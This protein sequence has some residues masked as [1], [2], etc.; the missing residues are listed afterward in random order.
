MLDQ[1]REDGFVTVESALDVG[2]CEE[3]VGDAFDRM[4]MREQDPDSWPSG[5]TNLPVVRNWPL[6]EVAPAAAAVVHDLLA[7]AAVRFAGV[8]DNLIVNLPEPGAR[9]WPPSAAPS[10]LGG[11]HKDGDW[12]RHFLDSPE[13]A[14]LVIV[15][16]RD[17]AEDQG[18]TYAAC[19]SVRPVAELLA[20]HPGGLDP[21]ELGEATTGI[22]SQCTDFRALT[23]R[24]GT[25]VFAHPFL[26]HTASVNGTNRPRV[27]SNSSVML[28][29]PM[30]FDRPARDHSVLE[31]SILDALG[32]DRLD[33]RPTGDRRRVT[34]ERARRW[35]EAQT[36]THQDDESA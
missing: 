29:E 36:Q 7:P 12:F 6:E 25:I 4:G 22:V 3:V 35:A 26:L 10:N 23:G 19:D 2:F 8:Q 13:Q 32:A 17:V 5:R 28:A 15:F 21:A 31:R 20:A 16:W 30:R 18:A 9:W 14:L 24:Q 27:I 11:W 34:S 1:L 33:F